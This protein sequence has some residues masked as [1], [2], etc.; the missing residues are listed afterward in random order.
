MKQVHKNSSSSTPRAHTLRIDREQATA[1]IEA[2]G[3]CLS[4][5]VYIRA[6]LP[7]EDPRCADD[8]GRKADQ[9]NWEQLERWQAQGYGIY[10]VVN[11][12]GHKDEDVKYC[13]AI[14]CEFDDRPIEDQINFWQQLGLPEPS[15]QIATRKSVHTYWIFAEPIP[16]VQWR[17]LQT[18]LLEYT[19]SDRALKN[20]SR[21][22][23]LAGAYHIK[24][25]HE[26]LRC[27]LIHQSGKRY[28]YEELR[29]VVPVPQQPTPAQP[30]LLP[31]LPQAQSAQA[32]TQ[33]QRYED[34]LL[35][36][37]ESVPLEV[38]LSRESRTLLGCGVSEGG[39]NTG[40]AKLARD[41]L[42]T[43]KYLQTIG[44]QFDGDPRQLLED[45]ASRCTPPLPALEVEAIWKSAEK[46]SPNPSCQ[47]E[48]VEACI[49]A[50]Y[51]KHHVK[52]HQSHQTSWKS[53]NHY[54]SQGF[55][56]SKD[57]SSSSPP[58]IA[59]VTLRARI[60]EILH[61][62][63]AQ[64][65]IASALMDLAAATGR[66]YN[67]INSLAKI[68]RSE[69]DLAT[70]VIEAVKSFQETLKSCRKRLDIRRYLEPA[71]A[72]P[73]LAASAAMP[74]APEYL[75]NTLLAT[76]ASR[77]G[78]AASIVINPQGGYT[79]PCI[80]WT[81]NVAHSG[82]AKTPPQQALLKPLEEMEAAAKEI[83][84]IQM[85]DYEQ[86]SDSARKPP[87]RRRR[88]LNN[89]TTSTKIRI[90]D[91]NPRGL[92]EYLD[93]LVADYQRL[94]Q[95][96]NGK[97]DDLQLELSFW[98][99]SGGN[100]DRHDARLFLKRTAFCKTGT[101]QW[102]TLARLMADEVN[103]I[104]SGYC[105][106]FLYCSIL[107]APARYL[108]LLSSRRADTL[109][110]K[111]QWLYGELEKLPEADYL[112]SHEAKVLFQGWNHTLV[113]AEI[114][115]V[116]FGLSLVYAKIESYTARIAL[117]LHLV[118]AVLRGEK[119]LPVIEG[120]TMQHAI[121]IASFY[122]WQH[123]LIHAHNAPNR[124][125][126]GIFL[127]VQTQAEKFFAKCGKGISASF[128]KTRINALKS[129]VVEKIRSSIFKTLAAA[130][131]GRIEGEG[132][133]MVYIPNTVSANSS[134]E[135]VGVGGQLV[136]SPIAENPTP[137]DLQTPI[138]EIG[139]LANTSIISQQS[140]EALALSSGVIPKVTGTL[141]ATSSIP[142]TSRQDNKVS[143][144]FTNQVSN[145][146]FTNSMAETSA[147]ADFPAVGATT[148]S[149][150]TAPTAR[151]LAALILQCSTWVELAQ[152]VGQNTKTLMQAASQ[153]TQQQRSW[154]VDL[155]K[156][157]LCSHPPYA[158]SQLDWIPQ[159][160]RDVV[161]GQL[162]FTIR[163]IE[164]VANGLDLSWKCMTGC[165]FVAV[166]RLATGQEQWTFQTPEGLQLSVVD[167]KAVQAIA[168]DAES[169]G[170][171]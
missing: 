39:R 38:C 157:H 74:T 11:G 71:L 115:E 29:A 41:L 65:E 16:T 55:G 97:G 167:L 94:N 45:Y 161:L 63:E 170:S 145:H 76:S 169:A 91:E 101:Y 158:I 85:Q 141:M 136:S 114:E 26:P 66:S 119:P 87:V 12:G 20:P 73:L 135:L 68:I 138:G 107:D 118:N 99:G 160:L 22:M 166:V 111:L 102:D 35:P 124:Q 171:K 151:E 54:T 140:N 89:V 146:Q 130:G 64:S 84:D 154:V 156:A 48:G 62:C 137:T 86:D 37:P 7:K 19:G 83:H 110:E 47:P 61:R 129:W 5:T 159:K 23:R 14:F 168:L 42:G 165:K 120:E 92:L 25:G 3:Q 116:H 44:Q 125:L 24:P 9:L 4:H 33:C 59:A 43:A 134:G 113:N 153:M 18:A 148:N 164:K 30:Q 112:L 152:R 147:G 2:L 1:Q 82:Q 50:W 121:E 60:T 127:K 28:S 95:F 117:W 139:A 104:A 131:H 56:N 103:F 69:G 77:I 126:E 79:Q 52:P 143:G 133:E 21:V 93:E 72:E 78:T 88:L 49:R 80:F 98:N 8:K 155:L 132:S 10:I 70:E 15:L 58:P 40:G 122:L 128:L 34:I 36:V 108:D 75:F 105:A 31:L 27:D 123:K 149:P 53:N 32:T 100:F 150:P 109:K 46:D 163:Q 6:F 81:A 90:H 13:R 17:Q 106:R 96:K 67:E 57:G 51:W 144:H 162:S 142:T